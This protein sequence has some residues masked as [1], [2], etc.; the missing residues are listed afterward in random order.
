MFKESF[1]QS[2]SPQ[3]HQFKCFALFG[4][5]TL[6]F[7]WYSMVMHN[8]ECFEIKW[9]KNG[10]KNGENLDKQ[11]VEKEKHNDWSKMC[12]ANQ[13]EEENE[14]LF[15]RD[16]DKYLFA[17]WGGLCGG[18]GNQ[19]WRFASLYGIGKPYGRKPIFKEDQKCEKAHGA[20]ETEGEN[21]IEK[22]FPVY[23][24]QIKYIN[25]KQMENDTFYVQGFA[26]GCCSYEDPQKRAISRIKEKY[27][28][29]DGYYF[30]SYKFF[31]NRRTEIRQIFQFGHE[32]CETVGTYK[33]ELFQ[34][35][36]SHKFCVHVRIE[37][38]KNFGIET[39]KD[40]TEQGI[41]FGFHHLK[42]KF[43]DISVVLMGVEK[44]FLNNLTINRQL[45]PKVY[46]PKEMSRGN[47]L[48]FATT[49]CDSLLVTAQSSTFSWWIAYL[50]PDE[51]TIFYNSKFEGTPYLRE[52]FLAEWKPIKLTN[53]TMTFD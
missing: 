30:Q 35:D 1:L 24:S 43:N 53:G 47:D 5:A 13:T 31:E 38:F 26:P 4:M 9:P 39:K 27:I 36:H 21:E 6:I 42:K 10:Q 7:I 28:K 41:E 40:F 33:S 12:K 15:P 49:A 2:F 25:P 8:T 46:L 20:H 37:D 48:A 23:A 16:F 29:I 14:R 44:E 51:A 18:L 45:I 17:T 50:M 22:L 19:M 3:S 32:L 34:E 52:N 11:N